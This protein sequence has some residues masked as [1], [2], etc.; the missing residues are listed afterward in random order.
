MTAGLSRAARV[1]RALLPAMLSWFAEGPDPDAG[2]FGFR[3]LS[4]AL[5]R[6]PWY[7]ST[8]RDEG[9]VAERL[10]HVLSTSAYVTSLLEREPEGVRLLGTPLEPLDAAALLEE[11]SSAA[12][13]HDEVA[14]A[15][16]AVRAV[17]RRELFRVG[18]GDL[19]GVLDV[20]RVGRALSR[21][22]D[23]TLEATL[24]VAGLPT[25]RVRL[26]HCPE[27]GGDDVLR[28]REP[29]PAGVRAGCGHRLVWCLPV[30]GRRRTRCDRRMPACGGRGP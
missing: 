9:Q 25:D 27:R 28:L 7:L 10:A 4:E 2:L 30:R 1:R 16:R 19:L 15:S 14:K 8:L 13:R 26:P 6:T 11:M 23:A 18:A 3:R 21:V 22:T 17:R 29:P 5:D 24:E 20:E 12:S